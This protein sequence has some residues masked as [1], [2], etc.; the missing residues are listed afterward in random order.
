MY[1][2]KTEQ[3]NPNEEWLNLP[4]LYTNLGI[5]YFNLDEIK[6]SNNYFKKALKLV[7]TQKNDGFEAYL[8]HLL[9][10]IYFRKKDYF[11]AVRSV[12]N[13]I[14][15]ATKEKDFELLVEAYRTASLIHEKLFNFEKTLD[16]YQRHLSLRD[17]FQLEE[18]VRQ[19]EI[20]QQ[21][22]LLE[23][24][25]K[26]IKLL[27]ANQEF[28]DLTIRQ[29]ETEKEKLELA[30]TNLELDKVRQQQ[31]LALLKG[32][33]E[34]QAAAL[35]NRELAAQRAQQDLLLAAQQLDASKK[36]KEIAELEIIDQQQRLELAQKSAAEKERLQEIEMLE[37]NKKLQDLEIQ[38]Q[39]QFRQFA[40][41]LGVALAS[42]L[43]LILVG[44]WFAH[45]TNKK[46]ATQ[47]EEIEK[48]KGLVENE[49]DK[50]DKL[51]L[52]ILPAETAEELKNKGSA[53][54]K[55]Y[56][57]VSVLFTDFT[58][59][60]EISSAF[61]AE[62][63]IEEL[64]ICFQKF[65]EICE[66]HSLE[67]IKTIGDSYMVAGG[68]PTPNLTNPIDAI[69]AAIEMQTF[70]EQ[71]HKKLIA[72][73]ETYWRMRTGI[74][75]GPAVAGVIG[76]KKFVY[77]IWGDTVNTASRMESACEPGRV[78]ISEATYHLVKK[79]F[80]CTSRGEIE[81]KGK[82]KIGMYF[83]ER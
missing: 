56:E 29:L 22:V 18:R 11:S 64:N 39:N 55:A 53:A 71:R 78:N 79:E 58:N 82:G 41:G 83:V 61:A 9:A 59:F 20:L 43:G 16:F 36:D 21:Q 37:Q 60:T 32:E 65:D 35:K 4:M 68:I 62:K 14:E 25:E 7:R 24:A 17:S 54:P 69:K 48:Q 74:H 30:S 63:V 52:N 72:K 51:L 44:L 57:Q 6:K 80:N 76:T 2:E 73:G 38:R 70:I 46:L 33:Q 1:F 66:K 15:K 47:N 8:E 10:N 12:D 13:A 31:Q 42:I 23:K 45:R 26:E 81:V 75:T 34:V 49:R 19:Q 40:Y 28:Q 50:A 27:L 3:L 77:D 5:A 67:K